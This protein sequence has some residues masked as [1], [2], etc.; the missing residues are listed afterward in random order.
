MQGLAQALLEHA[1]VGQAGQRVVV[2]QVGH[3]VAAA[4]ELVHLLADL[5]LHVAKA[6]RQFAQLVPALHRQGAVWPPP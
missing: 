2:R 5:C 6:T 4:V 3:G 1:A